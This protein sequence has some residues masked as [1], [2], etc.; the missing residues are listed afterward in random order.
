[1]PGLEALRELSYAKKSGPFRAPA[2]ATA[3]LSGSAR[4]NNLRRM[5]KERKALEDATPD[6]PRAMGVREATKIADLP[7]HLRGSH[8][9]LGEE[10]P[11]RFLRVV[12]GE[13][14]T[15]F[16]PQQSGRLQLAEWLTQQPTIR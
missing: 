1:M 9:T 12:A 10:V 15:P 8:W 6:L 7:I 13:N 5:E 3:I 14:Q 16:P 4:V 11:R 2:N